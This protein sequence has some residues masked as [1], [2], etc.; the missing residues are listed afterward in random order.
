MRLLAIQQE[1]QLRQLQA[2]RLQAEAPPRLPEP[3]QVAVS[4]SVPREMVTTKAQPQQVATV[5]NRSSNNANPSPAQLAE[6]LR[7]SVVNGVSNVNN[8]F[9]PLLGTNQQEQRLA[10]PQS[11]ARQE[12]ETAAVRT[13]L[14]GR[15]PV[16]S[17][18]PNYGLLP[19]EEPSSS[20]IQARFTADDVP[21]R[22]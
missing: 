11:P 16:S 1:R 8:I 14:P 13:V 3:R 4:Q 20:I 12:T 9:A 15:P 21:I 22:P 6:N 2:A 19:D 10:N 18:A 17:V 5:A 7:T